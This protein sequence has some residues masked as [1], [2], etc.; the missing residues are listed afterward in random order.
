LRWGA[1]GI[2]APPD[3]EAV[4]PFGEALQRNKA[5]F[6]GCKR[7]HFILQHLSSKL[8]VL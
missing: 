1:K 2:T 5:S 8:E 3:G 4:I 7:G 6:A